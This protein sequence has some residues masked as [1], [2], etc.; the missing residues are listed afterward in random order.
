[1]LLIIPQLIALKVI[2]RVEIFLLFSI[3]GFINRIEALHEAVCIH[4]ENSCLEEKIFIKRVNAE[5]NLRSQVISPVNS[6][7]YVEIHYGPYFCQG[8]SWI[9]QDVDSMKHIFSRCIIETKTIQMSDGMFASYSTLINRL[10]SSV[11]TACSFGPKFEQKVPRNFTL[12][13]DE[14]VKLGWRLSLSQTF[15]CVAYSGTTHEGSDSV[16]P[17]A[18]HSILKVAKKLGPSL[19]KNRSPEAREVFTGFG[20]S[21]SCIFTTIDVVDGIIN[22]NVRWNSS[23]EESQRINTSLIRLVCNEHIL[24]SLRAQRKR[25]H[26]AN[27]IAITDVALSDLLDP[28]KTINLIS[29]VSIFV[30]FNTI[31]QS[32]QMSPTPLEREEVKLYLEHFL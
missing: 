7:V 19:F 15:H 24:Y 10:I 32:T 3:Q 13:V 9:T 20:I 22:S 6:V 21:W 23:D 4:E 29:L 31:V 16:L 12:R 27:Q 1:M 26:S 2:I 28:T 11:S 25:R 5:G 18:S 8:S 30:Q 14:I 17:R